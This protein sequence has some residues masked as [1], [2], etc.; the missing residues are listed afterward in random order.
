MKNRTVIGIVCMLLAVAVCFGVA[1]LIN[2]AADK[3]VDVL[4]A[5][6][7]IRQGQMITEQD[8]KVEKM[9]VYGITATA[10]KDK[11]AVIGMYAACDIKQDAIL[12]EA[13]TNQQ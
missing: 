4:C 11:E 1:P 6:A 12:L 13:N 10:I 7:D 3:K 9:G 5:A 8:I 2:K